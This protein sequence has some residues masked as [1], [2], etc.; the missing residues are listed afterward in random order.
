LRVDQ[1]KWID[2]QLYDLADDLSEKHDVAR[3]QPER[4]KAMS[5]R[6]AELYNAV[7]TRP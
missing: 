7:K 3:D 4:A 5:A 1:W 2:G 6:L